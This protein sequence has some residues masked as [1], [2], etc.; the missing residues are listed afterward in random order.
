MLKPYVYAHIRPD[1]NEIFYIGISSNKGKAYGYKRMFYTHSRNKIWAS[2]F[3]K[4]NKTIIV[5][6]LFEFDNYEDC[7]KK[8][9]ELIKKYGR[10]FNNSGTLANL[11]VGGDISFKE[12]NKILQYD[13]DGV[14]IKEWS[15]IKSILNFF[16]VTNDSSF[17]K[18]IRT[19]NLFK[20]YQWRIK[21]DSIPLKI[22][23]W[24]NGNLKPIYQFDEKCN[25]ICKYNSVSEAA[26]KLKKA[27]CSI[28]HCLN[29]RTKT[30][31]GFLFSFENYMQNEIITYLQY[32]VKNNFLKEFKT[33]KEASDFIGVKNVRYIANNADKNIV[34]HGY[35]WKT[36]TYYYDSKKKE[37]ML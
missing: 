26:T 31:G 35:L 18:S 14:F 1:T 30:S 2:I 15:S 28:S 21:T 8:E 17:Y 27:I 37:I 5:K 19:N 29:K 12:H 11:S 3:N 16:N 32:D 36:K 6:I 34:T 25:L 10:I 9:I 23:K 7:R 13:K 4:N 22:D 24:V 33:T 20:G